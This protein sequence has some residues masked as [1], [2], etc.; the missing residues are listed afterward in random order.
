MACQASGSLLIH[1]YVTMEYSIRFQKACVYFGLYDD[2]EPTKFLMTCFHSRRATRIWGRLA[3]ILDH[4]MVARCQQRGVG[5]SMRRRRLERKPI[6][7]APHARPLVQGERL[8]PDELD[9]HTELL[10]E[11]RAVVHAVCQSSQATAVCNDVDVRPIYVCSHGINGAQK[12]RQRHEVR[13]ICSVR[14]RRGR[15]RCKLEGCFRARP[16]ARHS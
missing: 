14:V 13:A 4:A 5:H 11:R 10:V 15:V 7:H 2:A 1:L 9:V 3:H 6:S 8:L 16:W 12:R